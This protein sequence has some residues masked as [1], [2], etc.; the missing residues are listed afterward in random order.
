[1]QQVRVAILREL[2]HQAWEVLQLVAKVF[3]GIPLKS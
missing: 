3:P 1:V 2:L